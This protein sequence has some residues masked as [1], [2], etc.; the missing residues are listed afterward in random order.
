MK[1]SWSDSIIGDA[2]LTS[3]KQ[4]AIGIKPAVKKVVTH[5]KIS[6]FGM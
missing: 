3:S 2:G 4:Q 5:P 1:S 6:N